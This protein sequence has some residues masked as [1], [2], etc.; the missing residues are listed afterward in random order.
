MENQRERLEETVSDPEMV[1]VTTQDESIHAYHRFYETAPVTSK[2]MIVAV[3]V[4]DDDA[5]VL[6]AFYSS[7]QKKGKLVWQR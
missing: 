7:R 1:I 6:T 4:L 3:K 5:F 2:Y